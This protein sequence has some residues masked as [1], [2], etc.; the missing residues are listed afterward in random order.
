MLV[1][2]IASCVGAG[3]YFATNRVCDLSMGWSF[4]SGI[5]AFAA[6]LIVPFR[7]IRNR[8][9]SDM[10][11]VQSI[12]INGQ[13]SLQNKMQRWRISPPGSLQEAQ[14]EL[15]K[16]TKAFVQAALAATNLLDKYRLWVPMMGRQIATMRLQF[17][18]MI[19]DFADADA[20]FPKALYLDPTLYAIRMARLYMLKKPVSE[21]EKI[22]KKAV[23]G[24]RY[25]QNVMPVACYSWILVQRGEIDAAFKVLTEAL[26]KSDNAVLKRNHEQLMNNRVAHFTNSGLGDQWYSLFLEEPRV[27]T[28]RQRTVYR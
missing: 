14:K 15:A 8:V 12:M 6:F 16:D 21:I 22:F 3:V 19:K 25:N 11:C 13:K 20:L 24:A 27:R 10:D 26:K 28:Q 9:K 23:K 2:I 17:H 5:V 4:T 18:W 1:I 7:I